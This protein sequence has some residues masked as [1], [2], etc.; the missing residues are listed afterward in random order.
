MKIRKATKRDVEKMVEIISIN[1]PKYPKKLATKEIREMFSKSLIKPT[2]LLLEDK[3]RILG[4]GGFASSWADAMIYN[5][6]WITVHP[7]FKNK[8]VGKRIVESLIK[9][10]KKIKKPKAKMVTIST[11]IPAFYKKFG[12][13][14]IS[15]KY[16]GDYVLMGILLK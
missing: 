7:D 2:Y 16:D 6:F 12:F 14:K 11:E 13:K 5:L 10:V 3:G 1:S 4:F 8:G 9:E 15:S